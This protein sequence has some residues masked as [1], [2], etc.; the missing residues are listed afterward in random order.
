MRL[1]EKF[2]NAILRLPLRLPLSNEGRKRPGRGGSDSEEE[3]VL[4]FG[5]K[6]IRYFESVM[7]DTLHARDMKAT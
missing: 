3:G 7:N 6:S 5:I 4:L 2:A 1:R